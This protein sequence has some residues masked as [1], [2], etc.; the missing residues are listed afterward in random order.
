MRNINILFLLIASSGFWGCMKDLKTDEFSDD[1]I[2]STISITVTM[3]QGYDYST[4][5]LTIILTDPSTGLVF[6]GLTN[7]SGTATIR[8]AHGSY[9]ATTETKHSTGKVI[10]IFNGTSEKIRV[11]PSDPNE[12][13]SAIA[14]NVSKAGQIVIK[15][16]YYGGCMNPAT[17]KSYSSDG[18]IILYNNSDQIAYLDSLCIGVADPGNAPTSGRISSWVKQGTTE[19][20]DSIPNSRMGWMFPGNGTDNPLQ[21]GEEVVISLN[22]IDHTLTCPTSV[23][24]GKAG[25]WALYDP[26]MTPKQSTPSPGVKLLQGFWKVGTSTAYSISV[27]SPAVFIYSLG[28]KSTAQ[29]VT[30][31]YTWNPS[32]PSTRNFDCLMVDKNLILDGIECFRSVTDSKRLRPEIDNGYTMTDG[33]GTGQSVHR[34][35]DEVATLAAGGRIVYMDTNNSTNDFVMRP[36]ASLSN[37]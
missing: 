4:A 16:L 22:G 23:N 11:T 21:P 26:I 2:S 30:D 18:Y 29:F 34:R 1:A 10:Y 20:R 25:Y 13:S 28:G 6:S 37:N 33:S 14:L 32:Y 31:T 27:V 35:I 24:L 17:G 5:G 9:I 19:L 15:E 8:V 36:T 3:P 12:V 7:Q